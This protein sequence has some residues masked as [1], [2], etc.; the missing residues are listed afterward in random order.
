[1]SSAEGHHLVK[2]KLGRRSAGSRASRAGSC[3]FMGALSLPTAPPPA[4]CRLADQPGHPGG[5]LESRGHGSSTAHLLLGVG[6]GGGR[7]PASVDFNSP[8][9]IICT[10]QLWRPSKLLSMAFKTPCEGPWPPS[11]AFLWTPPKNLMELF[12]PFAL[13]SRP[14]HKTVLLLSVAPCL[15]FPLPVLPL[16][17]PH[18]PFKVRLRCLC[19]LKRSPAPHTGLS[20]APLGNPTTSQRS[21]TPL[22]FYT[23]MTYLRLFLPFR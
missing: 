14:S 22:I 1:M 7:S 4:P 20:L 15:G 18:R 12:L 16:V 6:A 8:V 5:G 13:P 9:S 11:I 10:L 23:F 3:I 21:G 19:F 17:N 2:I